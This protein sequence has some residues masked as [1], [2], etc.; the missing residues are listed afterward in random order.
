MEAVPNPRFSEN[1]LRPRRIRFNLVAERL[2][3]GSKVAGVTAASASPDAPEKFGM[4]QG[5]F[6]MPHQKEEKIELVR[7]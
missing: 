7:R 4:R 6:R 5:H 3:I 1:I 2:N